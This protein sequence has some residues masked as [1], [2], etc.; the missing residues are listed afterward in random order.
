MMGTR[1]FAHPT[2]VLYLIA[3]SCLPTNE[4]V[5]LLNSREF[6]HGWT[7]LNSG[8]AAGIRPAGG[9]VSVKSASGQKCKGEP[10]DFAQ[11]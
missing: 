9:W 5:G 7:P 4:I 10:F 2:K 8:E 1:C 3:P 6:G 11:G